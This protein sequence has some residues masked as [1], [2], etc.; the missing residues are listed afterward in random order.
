MAREINT[1]ALRELRRAVGISGR[2]L[3]RRAG[4]HPASVSKIERG[5]HP[6]I[7][8][9]QRKLADALGVSLDAITIPVP[10]TQVAS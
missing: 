10:E 7:P 9:T 6:V 3:G 1:A 5:I 4:I 8:E 2:E